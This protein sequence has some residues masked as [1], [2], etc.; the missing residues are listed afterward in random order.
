[1]T[2]DQGSPGLKRLQCRPVR[3]CASSGTGTSTSCV[4][5]GLAALYVESTRT[6]RIPRRRVPLR[7]RVRVRDASSPCSQ[8]A[9]ATPA[10][11]LF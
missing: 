8:L 4:V 3:Q 9:L 2:G 10:Y 1:M 5:H 11:F 6:V 7:V